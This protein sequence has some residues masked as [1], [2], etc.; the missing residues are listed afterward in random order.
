MCLYY[1]W[2]HH[3]LLHHGGHTGQ[4]HHVV[5]LPYWCTILLD[6]ARRHGL[7]LGLSDEASAGRGDR[8]ATV[9]R[10]TNGANARRCVV[11]V[12]GAAMDAG[13][14]VVTLVPP[15][16]ETVEDFFIVTDF[17]GKSGTVE[18]KVGDGR[19]VVVVVSVVVGAATSTPSVAV[20]GASAIICATVASVIVI[21]V[22]AVVIVVVVGVAGVAI[23]VVV[24]PVTVPSI[25]VVL[26]LLRAEC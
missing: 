1:H 20:A 15:V 22:V 2:G 17:G 13:V 21:V 12:V 7:S 10:V 3:W 25:I 18:T 26:A 19:I 6:G 5:C 14:R 11:S 16:C 24:A 4:L 9:H 8:A 23:I